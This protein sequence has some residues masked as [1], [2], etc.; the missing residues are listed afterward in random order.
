MH[1]LSQLAWGLAPKTATPHGDYYQPHLPQRVL[2]RVAIDVEK[3]GQPAG[4]G[5]HGE[6]DVVVLTSKYQ[7][8]IDVLDGFAYSGGINLPQF[9]GSYV[10]HPKAKAVLL[11]LE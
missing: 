8:S 1:P 3:N 5:R 6:P 10:E 9:N 4:F 7:A 11:S 2:E